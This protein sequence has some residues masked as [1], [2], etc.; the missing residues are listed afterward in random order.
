[1]STRVLKP[2]TGERSA[3]PAPSCSAGEG[4]AKRAVTITAG[5]NADIRSGLR[6]L[7]E[8]RELLSFLTWRDVKVRYRQTFLGALWA[9]LQPLLTMIVF[10][11]VFGR[12]AGMPSDGIPYPLFSYAAL[13]PWTFFANAVTSS[14]TSVVG[15]AH[16]ITKVY[17]PRLI[18]PGAAVLAGL[19]DFGIAFVL[20]LGL[21]LW[22]GTPLAATILLV[23]VLV[24]LTALLALGVG[25]WTAAMHVKYRDFRYAVPFAIQ[26]W[27]FATPV[28]YPSRLV[29]ESWRWLLD[30]NPLTGIVEGFRG[31][32]F[33]GCIPWMSLGVTTILTILGFIY[34][35][36]TF[37]RMERSFADI[38]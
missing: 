29:P 22:Y 37:R 9:V 19:V 6:E 36:Y 12:L 17:F 33:S 16:L 3:R 1:M 27:M 30:L 32:L 14:S 28:I 20:L 7:W 4:V 11:L 13:L 18:I 31:I 26:L 38:I 24:F 8:Y 5:T 15:S 35:A 10:T 2:A 23:P 21:M 25:D 34:A